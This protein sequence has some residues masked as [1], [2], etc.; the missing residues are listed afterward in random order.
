MRCGG[1]ARSGGLGWLLFGGDR[2]FDIGQGFFVNFIRSSGFLALAELVFVG[3]EEAWFDRAAGERAFCSDARL[4]S[5][6]TLG[7]VR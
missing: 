1:L 3:E 6:G 7:E 4:A 2:E 5:E